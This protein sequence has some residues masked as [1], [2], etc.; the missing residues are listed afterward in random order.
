MFARSE[1]IGVRSSWLASAIR[2]RWACTERSSASSVALKLSA[3][4]AS[5]SWPST[6]S[7]RDR[8]RLP[9]Q[10]LRAPREARDRRERRARD[11]RTEH[12]REHD[13]SA[14]DQREQQQ[15]PA[16]LVFDLRQGTRDEHRA[17]RAG[18]RP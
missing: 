3:S 15:Q 12:R 4:R 1:E 8:S 10:R 17:A 2:W 5:S 13:P 18:A 16:Q 7:R 14:A 6:S 11:E 9:R